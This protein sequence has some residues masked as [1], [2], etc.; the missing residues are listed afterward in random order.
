MEMQY[1]D[2]SN[3]PLYSLCKPDPI[4]KKQDIIEMKNNNTNIQYKVVPIKGS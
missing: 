1:K 3:Q 2:D 4:N